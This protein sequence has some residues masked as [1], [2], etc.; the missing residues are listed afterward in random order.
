MNTKQILL[1]KRQE[2]IQIAEKHG[3]YNL[4]IFGSV[5]REE[6][7]EASDIDLLVDYDLDRIT[8][9][10]P[11][12]LKQDLEKLLN[13]KVDIVTKKGLKARIKNRVLQEAIDL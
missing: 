10:F 7:D 5:A 8:A 9:W 3:A 6:D 12:G 4:R 11:V 1:E 13:K 2:I